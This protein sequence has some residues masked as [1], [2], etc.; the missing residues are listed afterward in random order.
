M[1]GTVFFTASIHPFN[2]SRQKL[3]SYHVPEMVSC[4]GATATNKADNIL[5]LLQ[6]TL[7]G[8]AMIKGVAV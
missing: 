7:Q 8:K 2:N 4:A 6:L 5:V 1:C 3:N